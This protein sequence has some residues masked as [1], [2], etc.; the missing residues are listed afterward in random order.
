MPSASLVVRTVKSVFPKCRL[1]REDAL[2]NGFSA[3][4]IETPTEDFTNMV[5]FCR[6]SKGAFT[7]RTPIEADYLGS[8][9]RQQFLLP[10][11]EIDN[12]YFEGR[13]GDKEVGILRK[14]HTKVLGNYQQSSAVGHW[15]IMRT[16]LPDVVWENW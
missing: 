4:D 16:V 15:R 5:M 12:S 10:L 9:A 1:F 14:G 6:K 7:F 2:P 13:K 11:H 3:P 8:Q